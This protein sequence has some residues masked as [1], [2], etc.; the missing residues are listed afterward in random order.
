MKT[1]NHPYRVEKQYNGDTWVSFD[2]G[3]NSNI[4]IFKR[5]GLDDEFLIAFKFEGR[6]MFIDLSCCVMSYIKIC[7]GR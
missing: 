5:H 1:Q 3:N 7:T 2:S 6:W 4:R